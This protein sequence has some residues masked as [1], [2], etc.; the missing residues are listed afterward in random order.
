[1]SKTFKALCLLS[2]LVVLTPVLADCT[3]LQASTS[4][5]SGTIVTIA[6]VNPTSAPISARVRVA[7]RLDGDIYY[8]L[9]SSTFTVAANSTL[10]VSLTA[11]QPVAEIED[12]PEPF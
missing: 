5:F 10:P 2:C 6:V 12:N 8:L 9:A 3:D 7:V 11:P 1:M 4:G